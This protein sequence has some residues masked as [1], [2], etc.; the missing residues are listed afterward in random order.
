MIEES[1]TT[2]GKGEDVFHFISYLPVNGKLYELDGL[3]QGPIC[4]GECSEDDW[5]G[6]AREQI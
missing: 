3:Q 5:L 2:S 6:K 4:F 1:E